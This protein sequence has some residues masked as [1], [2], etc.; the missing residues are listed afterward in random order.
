M[1][2]SLLVR[3]YPSRWRRRYEDEFRALLEE[4]PVSARLVLDVIAAA[5]AAT[6]LVLPALVLL[7]SAAVR[8]MQPVQYQPARAADTIFNWFA[9]IK[10]GP[11]VL[12]LG[13][14]L[15]LVLGLVALWRRLA[16]DG[17]LRTDV[18]TFLAVSGR[19]LRRP[20]LVAGV[21]AVLG[22]LAVLTFVLDHSIAG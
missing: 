14:L 22:S 16:D 3:L 11:V 1:R 15:A 10:A 21:F 9:S 17:E 7:A 18:G 13:P 12:V 4:E 5:F 8:L 20:A 6:L 19:L 2:P